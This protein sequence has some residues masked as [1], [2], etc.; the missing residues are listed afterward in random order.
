M[1]WPLT[2]IMGTFTSKAQVS[3]EVELNSCLG[4]GMIQEQ[5]TADPRPQ[6]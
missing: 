5:L 1:L 6:G 3:G 4:A 2:K